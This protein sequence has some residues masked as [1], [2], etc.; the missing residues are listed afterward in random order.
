MEKRPKDSGSTRPASAPQRKLG[1]GAIRKPASANSI[2][3]NKANSE[4]RKARDEARR[5]LI[6]EKRKAMKNLKKEDD[7]SLFIV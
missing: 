7:G 3:S 6:E 4:L 5:K 2:E 1:G